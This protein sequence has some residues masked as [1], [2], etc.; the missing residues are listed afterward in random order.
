MGA[1][2]ADGGSAAGGAEGDGGVEEAFL[3]GGEVGLLGEV[4]GTGAGGEGEGDDG[5]ED[6]LKFGVVFHGWDANFAIGLHGSMV[7]K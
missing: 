4:D 1:E 6:E 7:A 5:A 2:E 3:L